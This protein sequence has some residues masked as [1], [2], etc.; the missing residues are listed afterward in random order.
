MDKDVLHEVLEYIY[1]GQAPNLSKMADDLLSAADKVCNIHPPLGWDD[2][3]FTSLQYA[4]DG[5]KALCEDALCE[6]LTTEN[7]ANV[8][9]LAD[10]HS[11]DQLKAM[12]I[13]FINR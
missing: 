9:I 7:A 5:L 10:M 1:T 3:W 2:I 12:A 11:V 6:N 8:L 4:L 13:D